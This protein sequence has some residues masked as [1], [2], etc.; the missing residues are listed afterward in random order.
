MTRRIR[1]GGQNNK[2]D[3]FDTEDESSGCAAAFRSLGRQGGN[4]TMSRSEQ[5]AGLI[6]TFFLAGTLL[7]AVMMI[8]VSL[9]LE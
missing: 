4:Q 8:I 3:R 2:P 1:F 7:V 6:G 9:I 5:D